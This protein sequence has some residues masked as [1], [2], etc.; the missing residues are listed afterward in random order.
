[1]KWSIGRGL[2]S[3]G[4]QGGSVPWSSF[5]VTTGT[6]ATWEELGPV[7]LSR[8]PSLGETK[9]FTLPL[10]CLAC[11]AGEVWHPH[12]TPVY[13]RTLKLREALGFA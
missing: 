1:M 7:P 4:P 9:T 10:H 13:M 3:A 6:I 12:S 8:L 2:I 5:S 11:E